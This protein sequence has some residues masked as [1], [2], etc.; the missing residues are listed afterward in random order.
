MSRKIRRL[1]TASL[2]LIGIALAAVC[3]LSAAGLVILPAASP[4]AGAQLADLL[5]SV[6]GVRPVADL[7]SLSNRL[8]DDLNRLRFGGGSS[9]PQIN[10]STTAQPD[11]ST[12]SAG[13]LPTPTEYS[14]SIPSTPTAASPDVVTASPA[15]PWQAYGPTQNGYPLMAR[16]LIL[17]DP[18][19]SYAGVALVRMD[20]SRLQLHVMP[21]TIEPAHPSGIGLVIP[22]LGSVPAADRPALVAAFNGGFKAIHGRYGMMM[23][24]LTLLPPIDGVATVA[25]YRDG[26]VQ[27]GAWNQDIVSS[28]D[29][30]AFRQN[31]PPLIEAGALNPALD[32][33][34][35]RAWGFTHNT[36]VAWRT[37]LGLSQDRR[38]LI[39]AVGNGT[40]AKFLAEALQQAGAFSA[41]QLDVN[42]YYA[43]FMTYTQVNGQPVGTRLLDQM[44]NNPMQFLNPDLRDF[45]YLTLR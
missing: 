10:W 20:L 2:P 8:R 24:G 14:S 37:A 29:M 5:R 38:F 34:A 31:C 4:A 27:L 41:M 45:F 28:P 39:F 1:R 17:V 42:Q 6:V 19:R 43:R 9:Q 30:V 36:D 15:L 40:S 11:Q 12:P 33:D 32:N 18:T 26:S 3:L 22:D 13:T 35:I 16:T 23:N 44:T 25:I 7:E 21:G